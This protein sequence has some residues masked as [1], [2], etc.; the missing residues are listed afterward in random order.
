MIGHDQ[1]DGN[2]TVLAFVEP[3]PGC[4]IEARDL[5]QHVRNLLAPYKVP[6]HIFVV[7]DLPRAATGKIL[8]SQLG[9]RYAELIA[10]S[11]G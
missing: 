1:A 8:K 6:S 7:E 11:P 5:K 9:D 4:H 10:S 2:E 3:V